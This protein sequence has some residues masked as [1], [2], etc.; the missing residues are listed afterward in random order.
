MPLIIRSSNT[1][2]IMF[3]E[4][5]KKWISP[6]YWNKFHTDSY[7]Y[8]SN[9]SSDIAHFTCNIL[10][11]HYVFSLCFIMYAKYDKFINNFISFDVFCVCIQFSPIVSFRI[12]IRFPS[13]LAGILF[14][15]VFFSLYF[16]I[17][18]ERT[19]RFSHFII[20]LTDKHWNE[21]WLD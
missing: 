6:R 21:N 9:I 20:Y 1:S 16:I 17:Y 7:L 14:I 19:A 8:Y 3:Q 10:Y 12:A 11:C 13:V 2:F 4:T 5:R 18:A 15:D